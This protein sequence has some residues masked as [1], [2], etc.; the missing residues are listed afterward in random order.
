MLIILM[1]LPGSGKSY[2]AAQLVTQGF[3]VVSGE[4]LADIIFGTEQLNAH[5]HEQIYAVVR[6][7]ARELLADGK[8][9][10]IDGTNLRREYREQIYLECA[11]YPT[12]LLYL[13]VDQKTA[14]DRI[15]QRFSNKEGS[16]CSV[17]TF[18]DFVR[19]LEEPTS[20]ES[21]VTISSAGKD[22][23]QTVLNSQ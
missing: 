12:T 6:Q 20:D 18:T 7:L 3:V 1:G 19:Q 11:G 14:L 16:D 17:A 15:H 13:P 2:V 21:A 10:V 5:E 4:Q 23:L 8:N 9:V 22:L